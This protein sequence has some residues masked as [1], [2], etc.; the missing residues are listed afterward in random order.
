MAICKKFFGNK[1]K[2]NE[3]LKKWADDFKLLSEA[4]DEIGSVLTP[5]E[6]R[7]AEKVAPHKGGVKKQIRTR[8]GIDHGRIV[9]LYTANPPRSVSWIADDLGCS[10]QTVINHLKAE[11]IYRGRK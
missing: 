4:A 8:K 10:V 5:E 11:G 9:A 2:Y 3:V 6:A 7:R 1:S